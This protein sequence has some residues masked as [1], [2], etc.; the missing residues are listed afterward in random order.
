MLKNGLFQP[1]FYTQTQELF[2]TLEP[3]REMQK[4]AV[5]KDCHCGS[6]K[7][8]GKDRAGSHRIGWLGSCPWPLEY[9]A[10]SG[11]LVPGHGLDRADGPWAECEPTV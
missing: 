7:K 2:R 5:I 6:H 1:Q 3:H 9:R 4:E 10:V 8:E 11:G